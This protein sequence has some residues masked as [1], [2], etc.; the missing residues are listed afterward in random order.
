MNGRRKKFWLSVF[1]IGMPCARIIRLY[2]HGI[3]YDCIQWFRTSFSFSNLKLAFTNVL[4]NSKTINILIN[5]LLSTFTL[6]KYLTG[7]FSFESL[8]SELLFI[9]CF[10]SW[11]ITFLIQYCPESPSKVV[12]VFRCVKG[13]SV[14]YFMNMKLIFQNMDYTSS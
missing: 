13:G 2:S 6:Q 3:Q 10:L 14:L 4:Y 7:N 11:V 12:F 5:F 8:V 9:H 1:F